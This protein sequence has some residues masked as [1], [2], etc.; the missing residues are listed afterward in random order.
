MK[1]DVAQ[2]CPKLFDKA[3]NLE[4]INDIISKSDADIIVLPE[5]A[6]TGYFFTS[7]EEVDKYAETTKGETYTAWQK[8]AKEKDIIIVA[9]FAEKFEDKL[10]NSAAVIFPDEE[11]STVY[12]KTHLFYRERF[13]FDKGDTGFNVIEYEEKDLRLGTMI[14]YDWRFPEAARTLA[15][16]GADLIVSPSNLVTDVWH[17]STP[18]RALENKVYFAVAN[19]IGTEARENEEL[20]FNGMSA[21]YGYNG[22]QLAKAEE[23]SEEIISAEFDPKETRNKSFN[24]F[25]DIFTDREPDLYWQD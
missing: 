2:F 12:R 14:C 10:F 18:S 24:E 6:T 5:L 11:Y 16:K 15:L 8:L 22:K 17:I 4:K 1:I 13:C 7:R 25:N 21:I 9:G 23:T 20:Y 19:R 3:S